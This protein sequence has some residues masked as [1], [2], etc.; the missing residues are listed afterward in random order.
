VPA[1][2]SVRFR[3][4]T[5]GVIGGGA[6][7]KRA[8]PT[9]INIL[10]FRTQWLYFVR[11]EGI[12]HPAGF[13]ADARATAQTWAVARASAQKPQGGAKILRREIKDSFL[14]KVKSTP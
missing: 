14:C 7:N 8:G 9:S 3:R 13:W 6:N 1:P 12:R 4:F 2:R 10:I 11:K 5:Y